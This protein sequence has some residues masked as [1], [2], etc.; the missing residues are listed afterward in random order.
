M[1]L[2]LSL[3]GTIVALSVAALCILRQSRLQ[4]VKTL[5]VARPAQPVS[6][7][8][9]LLAPTKAGG[10][11]V[12]MTG[13][14]EPSREELGAL[15]ATFGRPV[16]QRFRAQLLWVRRYASHVL[17][18]LYVAESGGAGQAGPAISVLGQLPSSPWS[19]WQ[20]KSFLR[21][22]ADASE[23]VDV[24]FWAEDQRASLHLSC[25]GLEVTLGIGR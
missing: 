17:L 4:W 9:P 7:G 10:T 13:L 22:W 16:A 1:I 23:F 6:K 8:F 24:E 5:L 2:A 15:P 19:S 12:P 11:S 21:H 25:D 14:N 18:D 20:I 3:S